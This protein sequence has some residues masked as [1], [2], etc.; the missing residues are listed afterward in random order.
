MYLKGC[1]EEG[2]SFLLSKLDN[3]TSLPQSLLERCSSP[4]MIFPVFSG[5]TPRGP[6][7]SCAE[8]Q[9]LPS[10]VSQGTI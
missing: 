4:L 6:W 10:G 7:F 1:S 3:P 5:A 9:T 8:D 2:W